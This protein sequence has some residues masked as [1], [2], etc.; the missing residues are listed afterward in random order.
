M[1]MTRGAIQSLIKKIHKGT[2][3]TGMR[4][5]VKAV[6]K[7]AEGGSLDGGE[8]QPA[9][10]SEGEYVID[11]QTVAFLGDGNSDAGA[12]ILDNLVKEIRR[13]K[14]GSTKQPKELSKLLK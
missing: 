11:A 5:D 10:L 9:L 6:I 12:K 2:P 13:L 1:T 3:G 8:G 14:T 7:R 4:D